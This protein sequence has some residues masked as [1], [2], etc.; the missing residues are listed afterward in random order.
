MAPVVGRYRRKT[1]PVPSSAFVALLNS[2]TLTFG[3]PYFNVRSLGGGAGRRAAHTAAGHDAK[4]ARARR[5]RCAITHD[6]ARPC[7]P[8]DPARRP[9]ALAAAACSCVLG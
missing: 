2:T 1:L 3:H 9:S 6:C 4:G 5:P 7:L 8:R